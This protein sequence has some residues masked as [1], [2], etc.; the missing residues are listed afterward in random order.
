[1]T[2]RTVERRGD[3]RHRIALIDGPNMSS[4][5]RRSK[6]VYGE[7]NSLADLQR[8][9]VEYGEAL[10]VEIET[11][12]SNH[13]GYI[14]EYIHES[15]DRVDAYIIN[16]AGLT[17]KGEGVRHALEDTG[18]P[19]VEVHFSNIQAAAGSSRGLGG[20]SISSS[21]THTATGMCMG[22]RQYSYVGALTALVH[23]LDDQGFL[24]PNA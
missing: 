23:A 11:F 17:T 1:M 19:T 20:G 15:A 2:S 6:Q 12:D 21:F 13:E 22:L 18:L 16:P 10:G 7:I 9:V 14:L 8:Y 3:R 5:G 24:A 4:L